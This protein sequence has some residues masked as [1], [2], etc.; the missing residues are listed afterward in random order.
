MS[1]L[2]AQSAIEDPPSDPEGRTVHQKG[3]TTH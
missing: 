2:K 1:K 3:D